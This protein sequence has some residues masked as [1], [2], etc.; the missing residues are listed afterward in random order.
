MTNTNIPSSG[1]TLIQAVD[2]KVE[3]V[4]TRSLDL[5]F[6]EILDMNDSQELVISPEYQRLF[7]WNQKQQ[8]QFI[9]SLILELPIPP[10]FVIETE[11]SIYELIDGL[12]RVSSYLHFRGKLQIVDPPIQD[13]GNEDLDE[14][15]QISNNDYPEEQITLGLEQQYLELQGCDIVPELNGHT[16]QTLPQALQIRLKRNFVRMEVLR[17]ESDS[18]LRYYMFKRLNTGGSK[19]S[20]QE[21]RNCTIRLLNNRFNEFL[22][23]LSESTDFKNCTS[24]ISPDKRMQKYDQELILRFFAFKNN[25]DNYVHDIEPFLTD[26]MEAIAEADAGVNNDQE[27]IITSRKFDY[28]R[29]REIFEKTFAI[30]SATMGEGAF[31]RYR[32]GKFDNN[33]VSLQFEAC[34]IGV[35]PYLS[36][37]D[38]ENAGQMGEI[39]RILLEI[40]S[41]KDFSLHTTGGG[42]NTTRRLNER[43]GYVE[44]ALRKAF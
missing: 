34:S 4:R 36:N 24:K 26:Y 10:I 20:N 11:Q 18:R 35:Q 16:Y 21:I 40:K 19:L 32:D 15:E 41:S 31:S 12:Q 17:R 1:V 39:K 5:S 30:L 43:I 44:E 2:R 38:I 3:R 23:E 7:R 37:I 22:I 27:D 13:I 29:E 28:Q 8:S 25:R 33:F 14:D 9:E 42:K 6:N